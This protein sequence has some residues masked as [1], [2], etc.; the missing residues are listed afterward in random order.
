M[1]TSSGFS[2][3]R[4]IIIFGITIAVSVLIAFALSL[5]F[6]LLKS[7]QAVSEIAK[8]VLFYIPPTIFA[9]LCS[10]NIGARGYLTGLIS[11]VSFFLI[12]ALISLLFGGS[13]TLGAG[14]VKSLIITAF[15]G[16]LGGIA[17]INCK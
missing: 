1:N 5:I 10:R 4:L 12:A 6:S 7:A 16:V 17:G 13:L 9:F 3:K 2:F 11:A 8:S 14:F 15:C